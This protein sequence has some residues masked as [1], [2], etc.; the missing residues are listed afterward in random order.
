MVDAVQGRRD[1]SFAAPMPVSLALRSFPR[2]AL[3]VLEATPL[4]SEQRLVAKR[5]GIS[6]SPNSSRDFTNTVS[7]LISVVGS[8]ASTPIDRGL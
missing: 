8:D 3:K 2:A 7:L 6:G 4:S 5:A 1:S